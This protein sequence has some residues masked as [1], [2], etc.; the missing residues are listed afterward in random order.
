MAP[1]NASP[2]TR[3]I[4]IIE[5][6]ES[7]RAL[8]RFALTQVGYVIREAGNGRQGITAFRQ[9]PT[10][11]V[12]TDIFMPDRDGLEV[13]ETLRRMRPH[14]K[15]LA[16]SGASGT[17]DYFG[18]ATSVGGVAVLRKPFAMPTLLKTV[19]ALLKES[20]Q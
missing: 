19:A 14:V 16:I 3:S 15:I 13:I 17:M 12:I 2:S 4:L 8:L 20:P 10:D 11:L 1:A 9:A 18:Q 7:V 6:E 5:D